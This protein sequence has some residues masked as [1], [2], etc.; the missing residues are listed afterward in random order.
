MGGQGPGVRTEEQEHGI[1]DEL[2]LGTPADETI[3]ITIHGT[4]MMITYVH[5]YHRDVTIKK[6]RKKVLEEIINNDE[7]SNC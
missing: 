4:R 2:R 7:F 1:T 5:K 3:T 6:L